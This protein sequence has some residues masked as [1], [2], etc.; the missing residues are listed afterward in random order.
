M[1]IVSMRAGAPESETLDNDGS[2]AAI[3][4]RAA[5]VRG[6]ISPAALNGRPQA[7]PE[8]DKNDAVEGVGVVESSRI[9]RSLTE[10]TEFTSR[11]TA[12]SLLGMTWMSPNSSACD[13][14][15]DNYALDVGWS[16]LWRSTEEVCAVV[17]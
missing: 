8:L 13:A 9:A 14:G 11:A 5:H 15:F 3:E 2:D 7:A 6:L 10:N 12:E 1:E 16:C 4:D 17:V